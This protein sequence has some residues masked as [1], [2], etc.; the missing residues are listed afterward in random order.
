MSYN[1]IQFVKAN[2]LQGMTALEKAIALPHEYPAQRYPSFPALERTATMAF[3][4]PVSL[5]FPNGSTEM[6][7]LLCRQP[8]WP[9]WVQQTQQSVAQLVAYPTT[10]PAG[11]SEAILTNNSRTPFLVA[12]RPIDYFN[13]SKTGS[14]LRPGLSGVLSP[15]W[16]YPLLGGMDTRVYTFVPANSY[17]SL[18]FG[19]RTHTVNTGATFIAS[20]LYEVWQ[21]PTDCIQVNTPDFTVDQLNLGGFYNA[22]ITSENQWIRP[23]EIR[24]SSG[25]TT[26]ITDP[27]VSVI[28]STGSPLYIQSAVTQGSFTFSDRSATLLVPV[29]PVPEFDVT[30]RPWQDTRTTAAAVLMTNVTKVLN[31]EGTVLAGRLPNTYDDMWNFTTGSLSQLHPAEKAML[32]LETGFYTYAPPST[33]MASFWDHALFRAN[34]FTG[35]A[36]CPLFRLDNTSYGNCFVL[37]DSDAN[38]PSTFA[39]NLDW[40]IEFRNNSTLFPIGM[41]S[42]TLEA[43]H[44]AILQLVSHGFFFSNDKHK[45][46][47]GKIVSASK[48]ANKY[49]SPVLPGPY[50]AALSGGI[51]LA[52]KMLSRRPNTTPKT[53]S[54]SGSGMLP[55]KAQSKGKQPKNNKKK[56]A[57]KRK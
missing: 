56:G 51:K 18:V 22:G 23:L 26:D 37:T 7:G 54:A 24:V 42:I 20:I 17:L 27:T 35:L 14:T 30:E 6:K 9:L 13:T 12:E 2:P 49:V 47:I 31:K 25:I 29:G 4:L 40:H 50:R 41:S 3:N 45:G 1:T 39:V 38:T 21:S 48:L 28:W 57:N 33:D 15:N 55:K 52:D 34:V 11:V 5:G 10:G 44:Q 46:L 8:A 36:S 16:T 32:A 53:T 43:F 19:M